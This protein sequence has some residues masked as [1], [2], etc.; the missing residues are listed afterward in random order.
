MYESK[1][2]IE[3]MSLKMSF[4]MNNPTAHAC[5]SSDFTLQSVKSV[6]ITILTRQH[7]MHDF[8]TFRILDEGDDRSDIL[9]LV[10]AVLDYP[11]STKRMR[12]DLN[13]SPST[14]QPGHVCTRRPT[15][16]KTSVE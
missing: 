3:N 9:V 4:S 13:L 12:L 10:Y 15:P 7:T 16:V 8:S 11:L 14:I 6:I 2:D 1:Y 5:Q